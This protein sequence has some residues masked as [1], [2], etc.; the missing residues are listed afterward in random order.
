MHQLEL[1]Q[2]T[3]KFLKVRNKVGRDFGH[4][5]IISHMNFV[6]SPFTNKNLDQAPQRHLV[7][8][9]LGGLKSVPDQ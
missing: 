7:G 1:S 3:K 4:T 5:I 9:A 8:I 2:N 6:K